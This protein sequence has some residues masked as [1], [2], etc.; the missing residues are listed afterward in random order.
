VKRLCLVRAKDDR[1]TMSKTMS[2]TMN[3]TLN[4]TLRSIL[5]GGGAVNVSATIEGKI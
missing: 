5:S 1:L 4:K 2:K 3:N